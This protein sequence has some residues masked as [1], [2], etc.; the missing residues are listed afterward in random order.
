MRYRFATVTAQLRQ[1]LSDRQSVA[2]SI[3][4]PVKKRQWYFLSKI[5]II[6]T[7]SG[8]SAVFHPR[9]LEST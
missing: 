2:G 5:T 9:A 8:S 3:P 4:A 6:S 7:E 1:E